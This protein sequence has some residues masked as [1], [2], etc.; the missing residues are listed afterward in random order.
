MN[1]YVEMMIMMS[2]Y[3]I[4][5]VKYIRFIGVFIHSASD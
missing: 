1:I 2:M 3:Q 4:M 5:K